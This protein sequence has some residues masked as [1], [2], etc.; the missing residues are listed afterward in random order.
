M[1][2]ET[3]AVR[4]ATE[5]DTVSARAGYSEHQTGLAVDLIT[6]D[7]PGCDFRPCFAHSPAGRW[8]ATHAWRWGFIVRYQPATT[9]I[10]GYQPEPWHLRY[11]G[12]PL[13]AE[14]KR[15]GVAT[16]EQFFGVPGGDYPS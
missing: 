6:P 3:A 11:V 7:D 2:A 16:L 10:T 1:H 12:G 5:A 9:A 4:G 14:L 13:A 15:E 8:L